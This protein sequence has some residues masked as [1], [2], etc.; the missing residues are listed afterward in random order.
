MAFH[1]FNTSL[2]T[3]NGAIKP[4]SPITTRILKR[5]LP[6]T[7]PIATSADPRKAAVKDTQSSGAD[8]PKATT[9]K[10]TQKQRFLNEAQD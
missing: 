2:E 4:A 6:K 8:V 7:F 10:P 3:V 1:A 9:V 5:L